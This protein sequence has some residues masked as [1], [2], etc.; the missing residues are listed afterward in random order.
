MPTALDFHMFTFPLIV[1]EFTCYNKIFNRYFGTVIKA[2]ST[3]LVRNSNDT[4]K[5]SKQQKH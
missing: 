3:I 1:V 2:N 5:F 4:V